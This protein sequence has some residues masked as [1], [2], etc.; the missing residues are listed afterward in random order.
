MP[1]STGTGIGKMIT[2]ALARN[3]ARVYIASRKLPV[4]QATAD[5]IN[6]LEAT[7]KSGG[8]VIAVKADLRGRADCEGLAAQIAK[9][10]SKI[11]ILVNNAG[12]AWGGKLSDFPEEGGWNNTLKV[13]L[14][15]Y[16]YL[17][18]ALLPLL[19]A[20]SQPTDPARVVNISSIAALNPSTAHD[21]IAAPGTGTFSYGVSKAAVNQLTKSLAFSLA[22]QGVTV[23]A[24]AP[25]R[26]LSRMTQMSGLDPGLKTAAKNEQPMGR[27]GDT[28]DMAGLLL[29]LVSRAGSHITGSVIET[30]G[31]ANL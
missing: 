19:R 23:N 2:G 27:I 3:G 5:E 4:L 28:N 18:A 12:I 13:N 7:K 9:S 25:G 11:H 26:Y 15:A 31:G 14:V 16:F 29:F 8:K 21:P 24:I 30:A 22:G 17:T 20:A 6:G 10:E 1:T